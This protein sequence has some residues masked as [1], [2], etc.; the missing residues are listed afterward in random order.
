MK[1]KICLFAQLRD[2]LGFPEI[3]IDLPDHISIKDCLDILVQ[4]YP[5]L[6]PYI[7]SSIVA[8]NQEFTNRD[9]LLLK[10]DNL[11]LFPPVSGG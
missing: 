5:I 1:V 11:A 4:T 3:E 9:H 2:V 10:G 7:N 8:V 6:S